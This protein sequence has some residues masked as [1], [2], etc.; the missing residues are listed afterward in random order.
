ML[1]CVYVGVSYRKAAKSLKLIDFLFDGQLGKTPSY[2]SIKDWVTK[3]G[4]SA[5]KGS[6][7]SIEE[8]YALIVDGSISVGDQQLLLFL[9]IP[10]EHKGHALKHSD[11]EVAGMKVATSWPAESVKSMAEDI[12]NSEE[13][14]P[15]Y[16]LSDNGANLRKAAELLG[17]D[18][19][20]DVSHT[21][22]TYLKQVYEDDPEFKQFSDLIGKTKH[23]A[24]TSVAY[25]MPCKQR[26]MAR[27]M[28]LYPIIDWAGRMLENYHN[29]TEKERF[30]YSFVIRNA[31]LVAELKEVLSMF[32]QV[33]EI[34][35]KDGL[36]Y[37]TAARCKA[38]VRETM[39][40]GGERT[41]LLRDLICQYL[42]KETQL[43]KG[44]DEKHNISS[45][46]ME[47]SFGLLKNRM[48]TCKMAGF[49]ESSLILPLN[50][51][52]QELGTINQAQVAKWMA[53]TRMKDV[54]EWKRGTLKENPMI[55]RRNALPKVA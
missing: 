15:E 20:R 11:V 44:P 49:T 8:A 21:F 34:L 9:K 5:L 32:E 42:D 36:T 24:L 10:A 16:I 43:L 12:A 37:M 46:I 28:N 31:S 18:H 53:D 19:H 39:L 25:L 29:L 41:G 1:F 6:V 45:D 35:K 26:R 7:K 27:F 14:K 13:R 52:L 4:L 51:K 33:M 38:L 23:L 48:S 47:S 22:A 30:H 3:A 40:P 50:S 17:I 54:E 2:T 55:K